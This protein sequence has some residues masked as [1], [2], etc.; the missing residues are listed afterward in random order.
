MK[1]DLEK[2]ALIAEIIGGTGIIVSVLYLAYQVSQN[3]ANIRAANALAVSSEITALR[4]PTIENAELNDLIQQGRLDLDALTD[5]ER[6][7]FFSYTLNRFA[8]LENILFMEEEGLLP[9][10]FAPPLINGTCGALNWPGY[11]GIWE[12]AAKPFFSTRMRDYLEEC[13]AN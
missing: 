3:T 6:S 10:D 2:L 12:D 1:R 13:F 8:L 5:S 9:A 4:L 11:R 7:R